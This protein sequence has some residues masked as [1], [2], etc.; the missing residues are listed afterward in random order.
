MSSFNFVPTVYAAIGAFVGLAVT[1]I[2]DTRQRADDNEKSHRWTVDAKEHAW[3]D[4]VCAHACQFHAEQVV[5]TYGDPTN[6]ACV[7]RVDDKRAV[8]E[9]FKP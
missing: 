5:G 8:V 9:P 3:M 2:I 4:G 6:L 7:C 1:T